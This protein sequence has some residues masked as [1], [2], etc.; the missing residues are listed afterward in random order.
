MKQ[1]KGRK[2]IRVMLILMIL[3]AAGVW[4]GLAFRERRIKENCYLCGSNS[5]SM[6]GLYRGK[7][8]LGVICVNNWYV[9]D[10]KLSDSVQKQ[11]SEEGTDVTYT[12]LGTENCSFT[13]RSDSKQ[14]RAEA[15]ITLGKQKQLDQK[16][17][18]KR[19]CKECQEKILEV[20]DKEEKQDLVLIDFQM[21][22]LYPL[23]KKQII[24]EYEVSAEEKKNDNEKECV[25]VY[26]KIISAMGMSH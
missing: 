19:F 6:V 22:Q 11:E 23:E 10:L 14:G 18:K 26:L 4:G 12:N 3:M 21:M 9:M 1:L 20:V 2:M 8:T 15:E 17:L 5:Q 24:R 7:D 13:V 25:K 16:R